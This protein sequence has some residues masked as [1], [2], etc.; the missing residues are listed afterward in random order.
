MSLEM[1]NPAAGQGYGGPN[2]DLA[3]TKIEANNRSASDELQ[4][5]AAVSWAELEAQLWK[6]V[7]RAAAKSRC[8]RAMD[9]PDY[10]RAFAAWERVYLADDQRRQA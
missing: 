8:R 5:R 9:D 7:Q 2:A 6:E 4:S 1:E 10:A 3:L